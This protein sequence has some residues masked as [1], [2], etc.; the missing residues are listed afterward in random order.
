M[1]TIAT[2]LTWFKAAPVAAF[3]ENGG[4][5]VKHGDEQIAVFNLK[6]GQEWYASENRC[7]HKQQMILARGIVGDSCGEPKVACPFHKK[8]FSLVSGE[9][10]NGEAYRIK[11][12]PVKVENGFVYLGITPDEPLSN[13]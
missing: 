1:Q 5:C 9:N 7:P 3:P 2:S 6:G 12:Y 8:N 10:L 4:A 13:L 11:V